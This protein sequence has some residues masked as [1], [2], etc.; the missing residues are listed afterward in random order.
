M[1][2][3]LL[4]IPL[5][6]VGCGSSSPA[7]ENLTDERLVQRTTA[8]LQASGLASGIFAAGLDVIEVGPDVFGTTTPVVGRYAFAVASSRGR[9]LGQYRF[10][11]SADGVTTHYSGQL[12]CVALYNFNG[13]TANRAKIG[14]RVDT[15]D[16]PS[17]PVGTFIWW[18]AID[19]RLLHQADQSTFTGFGDEA[20]N[21]AF[22]SS[23]NPPRFGPFDVQQGDIIV[24][25]SP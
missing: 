1:R 7:E 8:A 19:N 2:R 6:W 22:C 16:D 23:A 9:V 13:L 15:T 18:Q 20:A 17:V 12:T 4:L 11:E 5:T 25:G 10:S 24:L 14:G 21:E 3:L